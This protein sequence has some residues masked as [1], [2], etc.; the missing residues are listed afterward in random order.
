MSTDLSPAALEEYRAL[1][2]TIRE[3]GTARLFVALITFV[4]WAALALTVQA[5]FV[6]P[7]LALL[8]LA[9]LLAGFEVVF[10]AHV[11]VERIG[12]YLQTVYERAD[13]P[14]RWEHTAMALSPAAGR[15]S[16][17]DPIFTRLFL[18]A[19]ALNMLPAVLMTIGSGERNG[20]AVELAVL[21]AL[22]AAIAVRIVQARAFASS[23]RARDLTAFAEISRRARSSD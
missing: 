20:S 11:G 18:A 4:S 22:H 6:L 19:T 15:G 5:V 23:Q 16:G 9:V 14:P 12:R 7:V 2:A 10:A 21:G 17:T 3:R 13:T 8:P 1:R